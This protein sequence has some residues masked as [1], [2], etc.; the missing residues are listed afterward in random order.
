MVHTEVME[1]AEPQPTTHDDET[2]DAASHKP[3]QP[4]RAPKTTEE[5]ERV[6]V[7]HLTK[8]RDAY[9]ALGQ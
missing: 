5:A 3:A 9:N 2:T 7:E 8:H 4:E 6:R 1:A